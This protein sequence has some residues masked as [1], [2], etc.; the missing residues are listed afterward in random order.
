MSATS[1]P[2]SRSA[3]AKGLLLAGLASFA[4][5]GLSVPVLFPSATLQYTWG[6]DRARLLAG[7]LLGMACGV[8]LAV[9]ILISGRSRLLDR[10]FGLDRVVRWHGRN[11]I[12]LLLLSCLHPVLVLSISDLPHL[13]TRREFWPEWVGIGLLLLLFGLTGTGHFR[14]RSGLPFHPWLRWHRRVAAFAFVPFS[15]HLLFS[16]DT[17]ERGLP[18][19][20]AGIT[21]LLLAATPVFRRLR[22]DK[23]RWRVHS[24]TRISPCVFE[25]AL[26]L[27]PGSRF[28][29]HPGQFAFFSIPQ[30]QGPD[31]PHPFTIASSPETPHGISILFREKGAWTSRF[32]RLAPFAPV[33]V[34][35]PYGRFSPVHAPQETP[36]LLIAGGIG[37]TPMLSMIRSLEHRPPHRPIRLLWSLRNRES[38]AQVV[39][40]LEDHARKRPDLELRIFDS[41]ARQRLDLETLQLELENRHAPFVFLCGPKGLMEDVVRWLHSLGI[42]KP[43]VVTE[44]FGF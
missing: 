12:A 19:W 10:L 23:S 14:E 44:S 43:R 4:I 7:Q 13:F 22:V 34:E 41:A 20:G 39:N 17:F 40:E 18:K 31:E 27:E 24:V 9:Q 2:V 16:C 37:I 36:L 6:I 15:L 33:V 11:A 26:R 25:M 32:S 5:L 35:G 21:L 3:P 8:L 28:A 38:M 29:F 1:P 42:R 30:A